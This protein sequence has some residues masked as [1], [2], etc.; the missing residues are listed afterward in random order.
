MSSI[1]LTDLLATIVVDNT[2]AINALKEFE[3]AKQK[4]LDSNDR[5]GLQADFEKL[6]AVVKDTNRALE[7][8]TQTTKTLA[9]QEQ[10]LSI[11]VKAGVVPAGQA[12]KAYRDLETAYKTQL[13]TLTK[14]TAAYKEVSASMKAA[15]SEA[16][17]LEGLVKGANAAYKSD[18]LGRY[19]KGLQDI[20][21]AQKAGVISQNQA[22]AQLKSY[23]SVLA[24]QTGSLEKNTAQYREVSKVMGET[25]AAIKKLEGDAERVDKAFR[26]D[27]LRVYSGE[28][29]QIDANVKN[30]G[31]DKAAQQVE[32]VTAR[33]KEQGQALA[34]NGREFDSLSRVLQTAATQQ[35]RYQKAAQDAARVNNAAEIRAY[36]TELNKLEGELQNAT[37]AYGRLDAQQR[38]LKYDAAG[39]QAYRTQTEGLQGTLEQTGRGLD[40]LAT[41]IKD[42]AQNAN[43]GARES[44]AL[45]RVMRDTEAAA[46]KL[47]QAQDKTAQSFRNAELSRFTTELQQIE[48]AQKA[49]AISADQAASAVARLQGEFKAY[50]AGLGVTERE[51]G[52]LVSGQRDVATSAIALGTAQERALRAFDSAALRSFAGE[53]QT[54]VRE[55]RDGG[56]A[57][58]DTARRVTEL[59]GR[60]REYGSTLQQGS[61][62]QADLN[63][64]LELSDRALAS[65]GTAAERAGRGF[66]AAPIRSYRTE[67]STLESVQR[68]VANSLELL[69]RAQR[70]SQDAFAR[71]QLDKFRGELEALGRALRD[72]SG[73][74]EVLSRAAETTQRGL[75][76]YLGTLDKSSQEH[77]DLSRALEQS[78]RTLADLGTA[79]ERAQHGFEGSQVRDFTVELERLDAAQRDLDTGLTN[80]SNAADRLGASFDGRQLQAF[81][82][83]LEQLISSQRTGEASFVDTARAAQDLQTRLRDYA[84]TL[85]QT[86]G[87]HEALYRALTEVDGALTEVGGAAERAQAS[88]NGAEVRDFATELDRVG[89]ATDGLAGDL[90]Q[91]DGELSGLSGEFKA[92]GDAARVSADEYGRVGDASRELNTSLNGIEGELSQLAGSL[93]DTGNQAGLSAQDLG[94]L[95]DVETQL[96]SA[97][98][99]LATAQDRAGNAYHAENVRQQVAAL[100]D[101]KLAYD[102]NE[103]SLEQFLGAAKQIGTVLDNGRQ[104]V[105]AHT[106]SYAGYTGA[107]TKV[108]SSLAQAEGRVS[109]FGISAGVT[110]GISDQLQNVLYTLGP[111]GE[112]MGVA[113][114]SAGAGMEGAAVGARALNVALAVGLVG[115][116]VAIGYGAVQLVKNMFALDTGLTDVA[117]TT[118]FAGQE[119]TDLAKRLQDIALAT[120]TP[121]QELTD[122]AAVAGS[123]G[124]TG[125]DNVAKFTDVINKLA[126]ATDIVGRDGAESLAKFINV[127]KDANQSVGDSAELVGNVIVRLGNNL[128]TTEAPILAMAQ[129]LA[130]L[131]ASANVSQTDILG[132]SGGFVSLGLT[133]E[134]AEVSVS[135][136]FTDI[137]KAASSGGPALKTFA[138]AAGLTVEQ[139]QALA[140]ES[141]T[142]AFL[143]VV[144][145]LKK[146]KEAGQD[147]NPILDAI[148]GK[149]TTQRNV[150]LTLVGGYDTL[151]KSMQLSRDETVKMTALQ[152]ELNTRL[153][154]LRGTTDLIGQTFRYAFDSLSLAAIPALKGALTGVLDFTRGL[155]GLEQTGDRVQSFASKVGGAIGTVGSVTTSAFG[156]YAAALY[157]GQNDTDS[158]AAK[159]GITFRSIAGI[160]VE[161]VKIVAGGVAPIIQTAFSNVSS[162]LGTVAQNIAGSGTAIGTVFTNI[163]QAVQNSVQ[164]IGGVLA[165]IPAYYDSVVAAS[166]QLSN[167]V[168]AVFTG[169]GEIL[170]GIGYIVYGAVV[171]P[172]VEMLAPIQQAAGNVL[173]TVQNWVRGLGDFFAPVINLAKSVGV[174]I[175]DFF[176]KSAEVTRAGINDTVSKG[177]VAFEE[178]ATRFS[179]ANDQI[180]LGLSKV[181]G[182][183]ATAS[184]GVQQGQ[185]ALQASL[186]TSQETLAASVDDADGLTVANAALGQSSTDAASGV[187][188]L[189]TESGDATGNVADLGEISSETGR[190]VSEMADNIVAAFQRGDISAR[191]A[192]DSLTTRLMALKIEKANALASGDY[193]PKDLQQLDTDI[194][195]VEGA[196]NIIQ[197]KTKDV[198]IGVEGGARA[199]VNEL[200]PLRA[201]ILGLDGT[202]KTASA[203]FAGYGSA[204]EDAAKAQQTWGSAVIESRQHITDY[205]EAQRT[206]NKTIADGLTVFNQQDAV[207]KQLELA[208]ATDKTNQLAA[209]QAEV[210]RQARDT[211][212][213][214]LALKD[215]QI[216]AGT[217]SS[218]TATQTAL[219][220][221]SQLDVN[222]ALQQAQNAFTITGDAAKFNA[223]KTEIYKAA[224]ETLYKNGIDPAKVGLQGWVTA[225]EDSE[226]QIK[227]AAE[228]AKTYE[229]NLKTT[230]DAQEQLGNA[231]SIATGDIEGL[232]RSLDAAAQGTGLLGEQARQSQADLQALAVA[233]DIGE[234]L[235]TMG[236]KARQ[237]LSDIPGLSQEARYG[238]EAIADGADFFANALQDGKVTAT[239]ALTGIAG[240]AQTVG[241]ALGVEVGSG[242]DIALGALGGFAEAGGKLLAGDVVGAVTTAVSSAVDALI[243]FF[244]RAQREAEEAARQIQE[245]WDAIDISIENQFTQIYD[246]LDKQN[247][248][249]HKQGQIDELT[250]QITKTQIALVDSM[251]EYNGKLEELEQRR[252]A[253]LDGITDPAQIQEINKRFDD[254]AGL[255]KQGFELEQSTIIQGGVDSAKAAGI[256]GDTFLSALD[257]RNLEYNGAIYGSTQQFGD[258]LRYYDNFSISAFNQSGEATGNAAADAGGKTAEGVD[259]GSGLTT[260]S[261]DRSTDATG[262]AVSKLG[263]LVPVIQAAFS[264]LAGG[265]STGATLTAQGASGGVSTISG[266][267]DGF[268]KIPYASLIGSGAPSVVSAF[269]LLSGG[270]TK[271]GQLTAQEANGASG[272]IRDA[273]ASLSNINYG[274]VIAGAAPNIGGGFL[275]LGHT[276]TEGGSAVLRSSGEA[277]D[278][279]A[280]GISSFSSLSGV[281]AGI[282]GNVSSTVI[283]QGTNLARSFTTQG[284]ASEA[285]ARAALGG[286][287]GTFQSEG[288]KLSSTVQSVFNSLTG[289]QNSGA[290]G[291]S[292]VL[293]STFGNLNHAID[294]GYTLT[295]QGYQ[296]GGSKSAAAIQAAY[297]AE[298]T[299]F[300]SESAALQSAIASAKGSERAKLIAEYN[301]LQNEH[302]AKSRAYQSAISQASGQEKGALASGASAVI[303]QLGTYGSSITS[304]TNSEFGGLIRSYVS[305]SDKYKSSIS[306]QSDAIKRA[307]DA[308]AK[309]VA[310]FKFPALPAPPKLPN[311]SGLNKISGDGGEHPHISPVSFDAPSI[312]AYAADVL[313]DYTAATG[314]VQAY[315]AATGS[316]LDL[317]GDTRALS[318]NST[319]QRELALTVNFS[320]LKDVF[321]APAGLMDRA[322]NLMMGAARLQFAA[323][324]RFAEAVENFG[325]KAGLSTYDLARTPLRK[326][327]S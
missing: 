219:V 7:P 114:F 103:I 66:D 180:I 44:D 98:E 187:A 94:R 318:L 92:S 310:N 326:R 143:A 76:D 315:A 116:I 172:F 149:N 192:L 259:K 146:A 205:D 31:F 61:R 13:A 249:L 186:K 53:L 184:E 302:A 168:N 121:V 203:S 95:A 232:I 117:K 26:A 177:V 129:R 290:S 208:I 223:D 215:S 226:G 231:S 319:Q 156:E 212:D 113:M 171:R 291:F 41:R 19:S 93:K 261:I 64:V 204:T 320:G 294:S 55:Q 260:Q 138:T 80:L 108:E 199:A 306:L 323:A 285:A 34:T 62:E 87:E 174:A 289:T 59:Q 311:L 38:A 221:K 268:G 164:F 239:E 28:L 142:E 179:G 242:A 258:A 58:D 9:Q 189:G 220:T 257:D 60:L 110:A 210:A 21:T 207:L 48:Q 317:F 57:F 107:L 89:Q 84:G 97:T 269:G 244:Q 32:G 243:G 233:R 49:G 209:A 303:G 102:R 284:S 218:L 20:V 198:F 256:A 182:G 216:A 173:Q 47:A 43:L 45:A 65:L 51:L 191:T 68:D 132:L 27:T 275:T 83:E 238:L 322:S 188:V 321:S 305:N 29:K 67:L 241:R 46:V 106:R 217:Q 240:V 254:E 279:I 270:F 252:A 296:Q 316:L 71:T 193:D 70:T 50:A 255:L 15:G 246:N 125:V 277:R 251:N 166:G 170:Q 12:V 150:L 11:A 79:A 283:T 197:P 78:G 167:S 309:V 183:Y 266:A 286:V 144:E 245:A 236:D 82:G 25:G 86:S 96:I 213:S 112:A 72:G 307:L 135:K 224:L 298:E 118:G 120:G 235:T 128:S 282:F 90:G 234:A 281:V 74:F 100:N 194:K 3:A 137:T 18:D 160:A 10:N 109:K 227:T 248:L 155:L 101:L 206:L 4:A 42:Y 250:Y 267:A 274:A 145:G 85:S 169:I 304:K 308:A 175:G 273:A 201:E 157:K 314:Q 91:I 127:T 105:E 1:G 165:R 313:P 262:T 253:A 276:F 195:A 295:A 8:L 211:A 229:E 151:T 271:G 54:L 5:S 264:Q 293:N 131:K 178:G 200:G 158:F 141:P 36:V 312:G 325:K 147:L 247:E 81:R 288:G 163:G 153:D 2:K 23:Q 136:L 52:L 222:A 69:E 111:A 99:R 104:S 16:Q 30:L 301:Q 327:N 75:Q 324:E 230:R 134:R 280:G 292:S 14:G 272:V 265:F 161:S 299:K 33:L 24:Q 130:T 22:I 39:V 237:A 159:T 17:R 88:F 185:T 124:I 122:L 154:S 77:A 225:L 152:N 40:T 162:F 123:L 63:R 126:V 278:T 297:N 228:G 202:V 56:A 115:A 119:L 73:D 133:A 176:G 37:V 35:E 190:T 6:A 139:F 140:K 196:L 148:T 181:A 300:K 263:S 287:S 214:F